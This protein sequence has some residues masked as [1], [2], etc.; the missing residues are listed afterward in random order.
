MLCKVKRQEKLD[1]FTAGDCL[2]AEAPTT[3]SGECA[4]ELNVSSLQDWCRVTVVS[5]RA[6]VPR[7]IVS[8]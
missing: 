5:C 1:A 8:G 6:F 7:Y 2:C 4:P 3:Y